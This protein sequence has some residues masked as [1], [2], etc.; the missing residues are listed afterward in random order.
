MITDGLKWASDI[1]NHICHRTTS[2]QPGS[3]VT[4][5]VND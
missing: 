1:D 3:A 5:R 4:W 2:G